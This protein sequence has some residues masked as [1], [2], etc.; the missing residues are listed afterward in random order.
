MGT[1]LNSEFSIEASQ[2]FETYLWECS[3]SLGI[4]GMQIKSSWVTIW[5]L[6]NWLRLIT[7]MAA[8]SREDME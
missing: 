8:H 1:D 6:W 4:K 7:Q 2:M 5:N 3:E